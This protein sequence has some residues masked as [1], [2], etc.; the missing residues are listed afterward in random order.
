MNILVCCSLSWGLPLFKLL[1]KIFKSEINK[2]ALGLD[3]NVSNSFA[4]K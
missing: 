4:M 3:N 1:D 2:L